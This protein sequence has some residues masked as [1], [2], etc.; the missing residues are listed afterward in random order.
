MEVQGKKY[1]KANEKKSSSLLS[2]FEIG[3]GGGIP[4]LEMR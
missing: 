2:K 4:L 1:V 3:R